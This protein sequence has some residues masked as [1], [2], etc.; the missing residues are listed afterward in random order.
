MSHRFDEAD[1]QAV[2]R[3][4]E[5]RRDIR[6]FAPGPLPEGL[7]DRLYRAAHLSPSV[8]YMQPWRLLHISDVTIK[9]RMV[10]IVDAERLRTAD[11][12]PSRT[13]EFLKLKVEGLKSCAEILVVA[14]M[15]GCDKHIFGKRTMPEMALASA[16]CAIQNMWLAARAEGIGLGWVSFFEPAALAELLKMPEGAQPIAILCIGPV[17]NF[18]DKPLLETLGWGQRLPMEQVVFENTWPANAKPTPTAY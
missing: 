14:L 5:S 13:A 8:G 11:A 7:M 18:P 6:E 16:A 4:I 9:A 10:E 17:A 15:D 2:Y 1:V 3:A 12:L